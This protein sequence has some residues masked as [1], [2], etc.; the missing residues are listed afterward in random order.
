MAITAGQ[1]ALA[2]D[3]ISTSAGSGS[4]GQVP[5]LNGSGKLDS[6]FLNTVFGGNGSDGALNVS[7]GTTTIDCAGA[8]YLIKN[9][10]SISITGTGKVQFINPH[11][12][13]T[14]ILIKS[15]G[16][17]TL[18]SSQTPMLDAS[19]CGSAGGQ[20][21]YASFGNPGQGGG[22]TGNAGQGSGMWFTN[23]GGGASTSGGSAGAALTGS[24][25]YPQQVIDFVAKYPFAF[26]GA[27]GGGGYY[28]CSNGAGSQAGNGG[29][30]GGCLII[31][32]AGA[33]NFTTTN[34]ISVAGLVGQ[35]PSA[36][37]SRTTLGGGGGGAAGFFLALYNSLTANTGTVILTGGVGGNTNFSGSYL[38][39]GGGGGGASQSAGSAGSAPSSATQ[40]G[41]NGATG[42]STVK[43]NTE[44]Y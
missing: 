33:F 29:N 35:T 34:G 14:F 2:S 5:K 4:S 30:G 42:V 31:E 13:G 28:N 9:F 19:G 3:F 18:T 43:Q 17:V 23:G 16:A 6:S 32:C 26:V 25:N 12:N 39:A 44:F 40:S 15:Q 22:N 20:G 41:G 8:R 27:G 36:T 24:A 38:S 1:Q 37:G 10:S 11:A 21:G 7:S